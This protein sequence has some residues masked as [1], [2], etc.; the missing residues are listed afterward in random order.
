M[1][2]RYLELVSSVWPH[3]LLAESLLPKFRS[4]KAQ[5]SAKHWKMVP[6]PMNLD[7]QYL[8]NLENYDGY[9]L[10]QI[11][12]CTKLTSLICTKFPEDL[13]ND[14]GEL[15]FNSLSTLT[16]LRVLD[17]QYRKKKFPISRNAFRELT[18]LTNLTKIYLYFGTF[19]D[20]IQ[21]IP[22]FIFKQPN[23][24]TLN[25]MRVD[26]SPSVLPEMEGVPWSYFFGGKE[27]QVQQEQATNNQ[28]I[29]LPNIGNNRPPPLPTVR[30]YWVPDK[31][32]LK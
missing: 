7:T 15:E 18:K 9:A 4:I 21:T 13:R 29:T 1:N 22:P 27:Q 11:W 31:D 23:L 16:N 30:P 14:K 32:C 24:R 10:S 2:I 19:N 25:I 12:K 20:V 28:P 5:Y 17:F 3:F 26:I 6:K 8:T